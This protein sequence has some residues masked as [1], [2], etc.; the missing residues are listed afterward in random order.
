MRSKTLCFNKTLF[1]KNLTRFWPLWVSPGAAVAVSAVRHARH[2]KRAAGDDLG[3]LRHT[4]QLGADHLPAVRPA[5]RSGGMGVPLQRPQRESDAH[6]AHPAGGT[7]YHQLC[8]RLLLL[9]AAQRRGG[10]AGPAGRCGFDGGCS[11][12]RVPFPGAARGLCSRI[13]LGR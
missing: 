6:P 4:G 13:S 7:F 10:P 9:P 1:L 11:D 3:L 8:L 2:R 5:L 12:W